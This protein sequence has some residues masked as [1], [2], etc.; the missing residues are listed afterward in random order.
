MVVVEGG[1]VQGRSGAR[2][3][4][5]LLSWGRAAARALAS[6]PNLL[7]QSESSEQPILL[8]A[9]STRRPWASGKCGQEVGRRQGTERD[10]YEREQESGHTE[11]RNREM[12]E[13]GKEM[14]TE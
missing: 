7:I 13:T 2:P 9:F 8:M 4:T 3:Q 6:G 5:S 12:E 1:E 10:C 14:E 11:M